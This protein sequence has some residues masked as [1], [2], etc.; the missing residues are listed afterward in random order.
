MDSALRQ[1]SET[2]SEIWQKRNEI[3]EDTCRLFP[4]NRIFNPVALLPMLFRPVGPQYTG[5][6]E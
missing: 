1:A 6:S 3:A 4:S 5:T 2:P